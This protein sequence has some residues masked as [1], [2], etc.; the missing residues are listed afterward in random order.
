MMDAR[1]RLS[2][3]AAVSAANRFE[4]L[5]RVGHLR[6]HPYNACATRGDYRKIR[7]VNRRPAL[8]VVERVD[9]IISYHDVV[10]A[11]NW[12]A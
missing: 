8:S 12:G 11:E 2:V 5:S 9:D 4:C 7:S 10:T 6:A 1:S 3:E